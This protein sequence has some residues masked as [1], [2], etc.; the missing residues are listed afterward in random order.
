MTILHK[1][2]SNGACTQQSVKLVDM[3]QRPVILI[4]TDKPVYKNG[5]E[6]NFRIFVMTNK[7]LPFANI[8]NGEITVF[9]NHNNIVRKFSNIGKNMQMG[10]IKYSMPISNSPNFG[11]WKIEVNINGKIRVKNF[12]V[13]KF[14]KNNIQ[15]SLVTKKEVSII[16]R[17]INLKIKV[18]HPSD[19]YFSGKTK[20]IFEFYNMGESV[21]KKFDVNVNSL[22]LTTKSY[23]ISN[24]LGINII[25]ADTKIKVTVEIEN[26]KFKTKSNVSTEL[27]LK[28]NNRRSMTFHKP[29]RYFRPGF[30]YLLDVVVR[31]ADGSGDNSRNLL[32]VNIKYENIDQQTNKNTVKIEKYMTTLDNSK[33]TLTLSPSNETKKMEIECSFADASAKETIL[34]LPQENNEHIMIS[35]NNTR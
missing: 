30:E 18:K 11:D 33:K 34:P 28:M 23:D 19:K 31:K 21:E 12:K 16:E 14:E 4:R 20:I 7:L 26:E 6:L 25:R 27:L 24:D 13:Q 35:I 15:I 17:K 3:T 32:N 9:D 10:V 2:S 22:H 29:K 1:N 8:G 5:D